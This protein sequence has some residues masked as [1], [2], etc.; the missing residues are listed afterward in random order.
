MPKAE[1]S[2]IYI[3]GETAKLSREIENLTGVKASRLFRD[4]VQQYRRT[5]NSD[6]GAHVDSMAFILPALAPWDV[7]GPRPFLSESN[8]FSTQDKDIWN[9]I[10]DS[11]YPRAFKAFLMGKSLEHPLTNHEEL[12]TDFV[13]SGGVLEVLLQGDVSSGTDSTPK[14]FATINPALNASKFAAQERTLRFLKQLSNKAPSQ[15]VVRNSGQFLLTMNAGVIFRVDGTVDMHLEFGFGESVEF[16]SNTIIMTA[17]YDPPD[18][19]YRLMAGSMER[20]WL[21]SLPEVGFEIDQ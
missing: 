16:S 5:V 13:K 3:S 15:I 18:D 7:R 17:R 14:L 1:A 11:S 19:K 2:T 4:F 21:H 20:L 9:H 12:W 8:D 6:F 10:F